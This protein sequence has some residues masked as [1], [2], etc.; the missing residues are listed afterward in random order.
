MSKI[1]GYK[2]FGYED[3]FVPPYEE[4]NSSYVTPQQVVNLA[5]PMQPTTAP[6]NPRQSIR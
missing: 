1:E 5:I 4:Q 6:A 3:E 2:Q